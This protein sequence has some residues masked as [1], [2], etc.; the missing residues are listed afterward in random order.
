MAVVAQEPA[1]QNRLSWLLDEA[2]E[3]ERRLIAEGLPE[4]VA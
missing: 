3:I 4:R 1:E 2:F